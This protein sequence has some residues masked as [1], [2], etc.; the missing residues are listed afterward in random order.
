VLSAEPVKGKSGQWVR[1]GEKE[2]KKER[3]RNKDINFN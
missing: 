2:G 1:E 3:R